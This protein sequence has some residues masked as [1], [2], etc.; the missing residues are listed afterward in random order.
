LRAIAGDTVL[1]PSAILNL[2]SNS[3]DLPVEGAGA[4]RIDLGTDHVTSLTGVSRVEGRICEVLTNEL[5]AR[6]ALVGLRFEILAS[7][8]F[9]HVLT[10]AVSG[11]L[12]AIGSFGRSDGVVDVLRGWSS[13]GEGGD[14]QNEDG[15]ERAHL[16]V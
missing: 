13:E 2:L 10:T 14:S 1:Q 6:K 4:T 3:L 9:E 12:G 8:V 15:V 16:A 7:T 11:R 5:V